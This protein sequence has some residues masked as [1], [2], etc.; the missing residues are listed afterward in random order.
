[1]GEYWPDIEQVS[2][3]DWME[4]ID[5]PSNLQVLLEVERVIIQKKDGTR[6]GVIHHFLDCPT[7]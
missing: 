7:G 2:K 4:Q 5:N 3:S 6:I 1:M